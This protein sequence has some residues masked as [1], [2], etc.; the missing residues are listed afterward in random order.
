MLENNPLLAAHVLPAFSTIRTEHLVPAIEKIISDNRMEVAKIIVSQT[1]FPTWDDLV[2]A[3]DEVKAQ[4][5]EVMH[6]IEVLSAETTQE[7]WTT[8][9][10]RC[11]DLVMAYKD[12]LAQNNELFELYQKLAH[13]QIAIEFDEPRK[14]VLKKILLEYRLSGIQ[15][16]PEQHLRL[17]E[18]T[19]EINL[20]ENEFKLRI[21]LASS[22]WNKH[23]E[24][25]S[26]LAGLPDEVKLGMANIAKEKNLQGWFIN[27]SH[28]HFRAVTHYAEDRSLRKEVWLAYHSRASGQELRNVSFNNDE[29]LTL[30]LEKRHQ[31]AR[32]LGYENFAQLAL[33]EQAASSTSNVS[34][35]LQSML[36]EQRSDFAL[37]TQQLTA[38]ATGQGI[39][40]LAPWDHEYLA[41]K[42]RQHQGAAQEDLSPYF[43]LDTVLSRLCTFTNRMFGVELLER[44]D[45]DRWHA[46]VR[47]FE[48]REYQQTIGY[49][50][51]DPYRRELAGGL[52]DTLGLRDRRVTAEGRPRLPIAILRSKLTP[53][54]GDKPCLLDYLQ[55]RVVLHEFGHCLQHLL[56]RQ[57]YRGVSGINTLGHDSIEFAS[58]VFEQWCFSTEFLIWIS[59][60]YQTHEPMPASIADRLMSTIR[61][62][63]SWAT[64]N[65]LLNM[66]FDFEVHRTC[67][68]GRSAEQVFDTLSIEVGHVHWPQGLRP[69]N[70]EEF[71][72]SNY[73]A[74][75]Y[76]YKWS[77]V[78]ASIAFEQFT[79]RGVFDPDTGRRFREAFFSYGDSRPLTKSL[80]AFLG[81]PFNGRF[82]AHCDS[83]PQTKYLDVI[84]H[85]AHV[86]VPSTANQVTPLVSQLSALQQQMISL[87]DAVP[88]PSKV[89]LQHLN[90]RFR[91]TFPTLASNVT[92]NALSV[93]TLREELIPL[94]ERSAGEPGFKRIV[95]DTVALETLFWRAVAGKPRTHELFL[96]LTSIEIVHNRGD[97]TEVPAELNS[98]DAKAKI[99]RL[100]L[101]S[102]AVSCRPQLTRALNEFWDNPA[103]FSPE[104][105][106]SDWL[107]NEWRTQLMAQADL[108][109]LDTTL[110]PKMH[111]AVTDYA[112]SAPDAASRALMPETIRPGVYALEYAPQGW[113]INLP[114]PN[115]VVLTPS[116]N[117]GDPTAAVLW[118]PGELLEVFDSLAELKTSLKNSGD[119]EGEVSIVPLQE[120]FLSRQIEGLRETQKTSVMDVLQGGP[121]AE[122]TVNTWMQ[123]LD[124]AADI[125]DRLDVAWPM[126]ARDFQARQKTLDT[127]LRSNPYVTGKD[128][129]DWWAAAKDWQ[130]AVADTTS[131]A[132][133]PVAQATLE[134]I[135]DWTRTELTRLIKE[136]YAPAN[137]PEQVFLSIEKTIID[138]RAPDGSSPY[139]SGLVLHR[140]KSVFIDRRSMIDW[141]ISNLT[142]DECNA[143]HHREEGP[144]S[145]AAICDVVETANVG[146]RFAQ[147]LNTTGRQKQTEWMS[148]KSK[149][150]KT[151][152]L[153]AHISGDLRHDRLNTGLNLVLATLDSPQPAGRSK[154]N[155]HAVSVYQLKWGESVLKDMLAFGVKTLVGRPSLTLY[156]PG[157]AD[158]KVF[159]DVDGNTL[160]ELMP[161][162]AKVLTPTRE[163]TLW[164]ISKLPLSEQSDYIAS[165]EPPRTDLTADE[166]I[167]QITQSIF[168]WSKS[169]AVNSF[170]VNA[171]LSLVDTNLLHV[172][173][174]TQMSHAL[175]A[176]DVLTVSNAE[177]DSEAAQQGRRR[178]VGLLTGVLTTYPAGRL[179]GMLGRAI[180]PVMI[181]G[182]AVSAIRDEGGSA[183]QWISDF[184]SGMGEVL[185]EGGED[186][187]MSRASRPKNKRRTMWS[188]LPR[189]QDPEMNPFH[190]KGYHGK[191]LVPGERNLYRDASGQEYLKQGTKFYKTAM[192]EGERIIYKANNRADQRTVTWKN[193][194]W[195]LTQRLRLRGGGPVM[196]LFRT[197]ET[198]EQQKF[199]ALLEGILIAPNRHPP[200]TVQQIRA[201]I[202]SM[203][204]E[205]ATRILQE[206]MEAAGVISIDAYRS[207]ISDLSRGRGNLAELK[208]R[209]TALLYKYDVWD[210]A[211][212]I[213]KNIER[214]VE[215]TK[216]TAPQI[217][218][219]FDTAFS[220]NIKP[221]KGSTGL[222]I[223]FTVLPDN[224]TGAKFIALTPLHG[225]EKNALDKINIENKE[226]FT[227]AEHIS[228][229]KLKTQFP[230]DDIEKAE[231]INAYINI[232]SNREQYKKNMLE[233]LRAEMQKRN[234]PGIL[235]EIRNHKISYVV[236]NK[237][238]T[239]RK[240]MLTTQNEIDNFT[241]S[242]SKYV[243]MFEIQPITQTTPKK[244]RG[245]TPSSTTTAPDTPDTS[246]VSTATDKFGLSSSPLAEMQMSYDSFP[247]AAR[248]K[249]TAIMDDIR[250]GRVTTKKI[251]GYY[252]YDMAQLEPGAGRGTWRAAFERK[253]DT[254]EFGGFYDY[255]KGRIW[256]G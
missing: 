104:L 35:F 20:L 226:M 170:S 247:E 62:Q 208:K 113:A 130:K 207:Q 195:Q 129:L 76:S 52:G 96:D 161:T 90:D 63:T 107:E 251:N 217:I 58:Q 39:T 171:A 48:V 218:A 139:G 124:V 72:A 236:I 254:W 80:E 185:A 66:F 68:D 11:S 74:R 227:A 131:L 220:L 78:L 125:G 55:V 233:T 245:G 162:V 67:G 145:Y 206:T 166:K 38:F 222:D 144:L 190:L 241:S 64:A 159:R 240:I 157:A 187:I 146:A 128:R 232:P 2:L 81:A 156:T 47:L 82:F 45:F 205:L 4:L 154:V 103:D 188:P 193:G 163:M 238:K 18:L 173:Y 120:N 7:A 1:P 215:G 116:D 73:A 117:T 8:A 149:Q 181:G 126:E 135:R 87:N 32:L 182:A 158:G 256:E 111:K 132:P 92:V 86:V 93:R 176:A 17:G 127:W 167:K 53:G 75:L 83:C 174:E 13:S 250:A 228:L 214:N 151:E 19:G 121:Y 142:A 203:P 29:V 234:K 50:F 106:V 27:L 12:Q 46:D 249:I 231:A 141:A 22:A 147:W 26:L 155:E 65:V 123:R 223:H 137:D 10:R 88:R 239:K 255:H 54:V 164:L 56:T 40:D 14:K 109:K 230:G 77:G 179:G 194:D 21:Q 25:E 118:R 30:L 59:S 180:L 133:D 15:L 169:R 136:K 177:R 122:E 60:H 49:L 9:A 31:K 89:A 99:E 42:V 210:S 105:N 112:L 152:V 44:F 219:I 71:I 91:Q 51:I 165:L 198:P 189:M 37:E 57:E 209:H 114:V 16:T 102:T 33:E 110:S 175:K 246:T 79:N 94:S 199:N 204:D 101:D 119:A 224:F 85:T 115:C 178:A 172:L 201:V 192:Q 243:D 253:G 235:T 34:A 244:V 108:L 5:D 229:E 143:L 24:D 213:I 148:L 197:P 212:R 242:L 134:A 237:G 140:E 184:I 69:F 61:T 95:T 183:S 248:A 100:L 36:D 6:V 202:S 168:S 28:E 191:G 196:S 221:T 138:P 160:R 3:M 200:K 225:K 23:I 84:T 153:A 211:D 186:L 43:A 150:I 70:S 216:F 41:E 252:W 97:S 98:Q